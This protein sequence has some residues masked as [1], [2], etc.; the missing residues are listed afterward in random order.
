MTD[1]TIDKAV[2]KCLNELVSSGKIRS[3]IIDSLTKQNDSVE[4]LSQEQIVAN[5]A[6][7]I[8]T[9]SSE[10]LRSVLKELL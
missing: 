3:V 1:E 10:L 4:K 6:A 9:L 2:D 7:S 8:F 5:V